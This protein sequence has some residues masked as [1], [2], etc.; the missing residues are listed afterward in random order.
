MGVYSLVEVTPY[1]HY[2][3]F[4][5]WLCTGESELSLYTGELYHINTKIRVL[6]APGVRKLTD[7][8][9]Y[10]AIESEWFPNSISLFLET[11]LIN[12]SPEKLQ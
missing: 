1:I 8:G 12:P 3:D 2:C 7:D 11:H 5:T 4:I 6:S 10:T 9:I